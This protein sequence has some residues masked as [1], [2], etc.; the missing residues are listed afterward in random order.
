MMPPPRVAIAVSVS[1]RDDSPPLSPVDYFS[2]PAAKPLPSMVAAAD[3]R[4]PSQHISLLLKDL[5]VR[6]PPSPTSSIS[7]T[8]PMPHLPPVPQSAPVTHTTS[9]FFVHAQQRP[10]VDHAPIHHP[11]ARPDLYRRHSAQPYE[12]NPATNRIIYREYDF[13]PVGVGSRVPI[14]RTT[15]ACNACRSRKVRCDAGAGVT[16]ATGENGV[17]S[18]CREAGVECVYTGNQKKRGPCPG[19]IRPNGSRR[20]SKADSP[21]DALGSPGYYDDNLPP[22]LASSGWTST[23]PRPLPPPG[24]SAPMAASTSAPSQQ[25]HRPPT[26]T[27]S[28]KPS[29]VSW[30]P[31]DVPEHDHAKQQPSMR[32]PAQRPAHP[33]HPPV[34]PLPPLKPLSSAPPTQSLPSP[35][36]LSLDSPPVP[37][38]S[39]PVFNTSDRREPPM[40]PPP[41]G[42]FGG[43]GRSLP[44]L[45]VAIQRKASYYSPR[46]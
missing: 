31:S 37:M 19:T 24:A 14:S 43:D 45:R 8:A 23:Q 33:H 18:R 42:A 6:S 1:P 46:E 40:L 20:T 7:P 15:K 27:L 10:S 25:L 12:I 32:Y 22:L 4:R 34:Q 9:P 21:P 36:Q 41:I 2:T 16:T 44:P 3:S 35:R 13:S 39:P 26:A 11:Y 28:R 30:H 29:I 17:C 5:A 38:L